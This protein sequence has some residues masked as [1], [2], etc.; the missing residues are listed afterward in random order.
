MEQVDVQSR[1]K[2]W[3]AFFANKNWQELTQ[4]NDAKKTANGV[5]YE[6]SNFLHNP[7]E[8]CAIADMRDIQFSEPHYHPETE[9]TLYCKVAH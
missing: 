9:C 2:E 8:S 6:T 3:S 7:N 1:K 5:I 4:A